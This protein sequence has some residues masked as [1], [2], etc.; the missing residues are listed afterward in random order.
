MARKNKVGIDYFS[1]DV[2]MSQDKKVKLLKAKHGLLGYAVFLMLLEEIYKEDGYYLNIDDDFNILF[3]DENRLDISKY[4]RILDDCIIHGLFDRKLYDQY[5]ILT[6]ERIQINYCSATERRKEVT[7][8]DEYLLLKTSKYYNQKINVNINSINVNIN[9]QNVNINS[10]NADICTQSKVK[11]SKVKESKVKTTIARLSK[12]GKSVENTKDLSSQKE[13]IKFYQLQMG[14]QISSVVINELIDWSDQLGNDL[15]K[16]ATE[17]AVKSN[18]KNYNYVQGIL[19]NWLAEGIKS[20]E[21]LEAKEKF[22]SDVIQL[23]NKKNKFHNYEQ[24][25][26][27]YAD[28]EKK[29]IELLKKQYQQSAEGV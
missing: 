6:S 29:N 23:P 7:F 27:D 25:E 14:H 24:R 11:E 18:K 3:C 21:E 16:K 20:V 17:I 28:I 12:H 1:H 9:N 8:F 26:C 2:D 13:L 5:K 19:R 4:N 10:I 22:R 15:V